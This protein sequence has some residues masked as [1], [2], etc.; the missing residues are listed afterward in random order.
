M[1]A[2]QFSEYGDA[3]VLKYEDR[4][5]PVAG[6]GEVVVKIKAVAINHV[7]IDM[8]NGSSRIPL[9]LPHVMGME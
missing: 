2:A 7:D 4:P 8:R 9:Q 3:S 6:P 5:D 1:K